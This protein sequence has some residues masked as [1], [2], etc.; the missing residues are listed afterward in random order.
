MVASR[1]Q[2]SLGGLLRRFYQD[3]LDFNQCPW[4]ENVLM[5]EFLSRFKLTTLLLVIAMCPVVY[6]LLV[7]GY[8][9]SGLQQSVDQDQQ[10]L[11]LMEVT[12]ALDRAVDANA[13][14]RGI[15]MGYLA[16][17]GGRFVDELRHARQQSDEALQQLRQQ[18]ADVEQLTVL[19]RIPAS[20]EL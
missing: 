11:R 13:A 15:S 12:R 20:F 17:K 16:S 14:E 3:P 6:A 2:S 9:I 19:A 10:T 1:T 4:Q 18:L 8:L 7:G 5:R